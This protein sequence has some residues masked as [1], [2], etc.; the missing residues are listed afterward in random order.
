MGYKSIT[1]RLFTTFLF[2]SV[3]AFFSIS[4]GQ[5]Q[6]LNRFSLTIQGG[7]NFGDFKSAQG[8]PIM[9]S[10]LSKL[11]ETTPAFGAGMQYA[12]TPAW[13]LE[14]GYKYSNIRG[15]DGSFVT[16]LNTA[17]LKNIINLNQVFSLN[18]LTKT[19][20]PY[21]SAGVGYDFYSYESSSEAFNNHGTSYNMGA[22][23]AIKTTKNI[24]I[25]GHYEYHL[26]K[27][28]I[29]NKNT[30]F[31]ADLL[32]TLTGGI[33]INFSSGKQQASHPSWRPAPVEISPSQYNSFIA[34]T[35]EVKQLKQK[36]NH[37]EQKIGQ[38]EN[39]ETI[40]R[41]ADRVN[42]LE[43]SMDNTQQ[44]KTS[45]SQ[46]PVQDKNS[47]SAVSI[48]QGHYVQIFAS[49]RL[50]SVQEVRKETISHIGSQLKNP[51]KQVM[52]TQRDKFYQVLIGEFDNQ[53]KAKNISKILSDEYS[54]AFVITFPRP[55][56]WED[57]YSNLQRVR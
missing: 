28:T 16:T 48:S 52:I 12:I 47:N 35:K 55:L 17:S 6:S 38:N 54:D 24:D 10:N 8:I 22:G 43:T 1:I 46:P 13:T 19:V 44:L 57:D 9:R 18:R 45:S 21:L 2:L 42:Q 14:A 39:S 20:N 4:H 40:N 31:K 23:I 27:N 30:G 36:V 26:A 11:T 15:E 29:D 51:D 33:R 53:E 37:L 7:A 50:G 25:F 3:S 5:N 49:H 34:N 32:S 41:L 56:I